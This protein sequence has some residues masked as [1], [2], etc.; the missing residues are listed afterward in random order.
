MSH[1]DGLYVKKWN[2]HDTE[3]SQKLPDL[4]KMLKQGKDDAIALPVG[5]TSELCDNALGSATDQ[6]V[7][8]EVAELSMLAGLG[9]DVH[10]EQLWLYIHW[11]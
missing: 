5:N 1:K 4:L 2:K 7:E 9:D 8:Q 3:S 10:V 11:A 6:Q